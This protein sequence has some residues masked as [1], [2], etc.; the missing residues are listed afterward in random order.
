MKNNGFNNMSHGM[1][2]ISAFSNHNM[3]IKKPSIFKTVYFKY[4][5]FIVVIFSIIF[6]I[7]YFDPFGWFSSNKEVFHIYSNTENGTNNFTFD[8]ANLV[9]KSLN[10]ELATMD[11]MYNTVKN[12]ANWNKQGWI[13]DQIALYPVI[14]SNDNGTGLLEGGY[15]SNKNEVF[16]VNCYGLKPTDVK[17]IKQQPCTIITEEDRTYNEILKIPKK[18]APFN[19]NKWSEY[20]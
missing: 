19:K 2:D 4:A 12:G 20:K 14:N 6:I 11:Q 3:K 8:Q 13:Q 5:L 7:V 15:F 10:S 17:M 9:C 18:I 1:T 16:G